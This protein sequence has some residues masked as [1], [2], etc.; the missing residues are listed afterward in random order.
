MTITTNHVAAGLDFS[1]SSLADKQARE[2]ED[3]ARYLAGIE[4]TDMHG[5][6]RDL[7]YSDVGEDQDPDSDLDSED[8]RMH[9]SCPRQCLKARLSIP[10]CVA[11]RRENRSHCHVLHKWIHMLPCHWRFDSCRLP[12]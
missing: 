7:T 11:R 9:L 1:G 5:D 4:A 3:A 6:I 8:K 10:V 12:F 2:A